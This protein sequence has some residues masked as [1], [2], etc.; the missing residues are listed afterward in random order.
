MKTATQPLIFQEG[1]VSKMT[2]EPGN[3]PEDIMQDTSVEE[4][5]ASLSSLS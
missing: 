3:L 5:L 4:D 2:R 1:A